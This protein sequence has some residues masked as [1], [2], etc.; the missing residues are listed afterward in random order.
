MIKVRQTW[1]RV[2][3]DVDILPIDHFHQYL[4]KLSQVVPNNLKMQMLTNFKFLF[5]YFLEV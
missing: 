3:C 2:F 5:S 1:S 4:R